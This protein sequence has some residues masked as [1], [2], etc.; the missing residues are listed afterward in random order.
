VPTGGEHPLN[1]AALEVHHTGPGLSWP[2][3]VFAA[4][5][6]GAPFGVVDPEARLL[7]LLPALGDAELPEAATGMLA[8]A[9]ASRGTGSGAV[10]L[11]EALL[12]DPELWTRWRR[13]KPRRDGL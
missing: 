6:S 7:L 9:L 4:N 2:E 8:G 10:D 12:A 5:F 11:A 13:R 3:L 1:L